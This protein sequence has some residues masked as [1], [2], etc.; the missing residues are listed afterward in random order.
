MLG[1]IR[2]AKLPMTFV[3]PGAVIAGAQT[4]MLAGLPYAGRL[5][6]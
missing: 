5:K 1:S 4:A 6:R 2:I 3:L